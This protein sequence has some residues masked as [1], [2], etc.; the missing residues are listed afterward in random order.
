MIQL[1]DLKS[2]FGTLV[3]IKDKTDV[4]MN[5]KVSFQV[6][7]TFFQVSIIYYKDYLELKNK[8]TVKNK[9]EKSKSIK[10]SKDN[11]DIKEKVSNAKMSLVAKK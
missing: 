4:K 2:K 5:D 6:G 10:E 7:R 9:D 8:K 3:L 11:K 1:R